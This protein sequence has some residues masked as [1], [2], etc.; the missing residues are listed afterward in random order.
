MGLHGC[1]PTN[2]KSFYYIQHRAMM[3]M[4]LSSSYL[5]ICVFSVCD[6]FSSHKLVSSL[7]SSSKL[8][9]SEGCIYSLS[10]SYVSSSFLLPFQWQFQH[11]L[12][13]LAL[14]FIV[15]V[16]TILF[17]ISSKIVFWEFDMYN[18]TYLQYLI[19]LLFQSVLLKF[20]WVPRYDI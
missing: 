18:K 7:S 16:D 3:I 10:S 2:I 20:I 5:N 8:Y 13:I 15:R 12:H 4:M 1:I 11:I 6:L 17:F 14:P 9:F 19:L